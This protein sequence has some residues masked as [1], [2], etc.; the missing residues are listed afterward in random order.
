MDNFSGLVLLQQYTEITIITHCLQ[1]KEE[2][3]GYITTHK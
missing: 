2:Q 1:S 3:S